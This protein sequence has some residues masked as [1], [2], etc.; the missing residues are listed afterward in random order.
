MKECSFP[1]LFPHHLPH[2][3]EKTKQNFSPNANLLIANM[4]L[5]QN[6]SKGLNSKFPRR[7]NCKAIILKRTKLHFS[8]CPAVWKL[9]N[10]VSGKQ[11]SFHL[12]IFKPAIPSPCASHFGLSKRFSSQH[13]PRLGNILG[14]LNK[15]F[16]AVAGCI[17]HCSSCISRS[18]IQLHFL[19]QN[20]R[21]VSRLVTRAGEYTPQS[22][23]PLANFC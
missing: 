12:Y 1:S 2:P 19:A 8:Y 18:A 10:P 13:A 7:E 5:L 3:F 14:L 21:V 11:P 20:G 22:N 6:Y 17:I 16:L 23:K 4:L 9:C 15:C